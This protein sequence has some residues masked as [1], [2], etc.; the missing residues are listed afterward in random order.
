MPPRRTA[1]TVKVP[2][3]VNV[4]SEAVVPSWI[5]SSGKMSAS[6]N[7]SRSSRVT[8]TPSTVNVPMT[9]RS[10][11]PP[12]WIVVMPPWYAG[13]VTSSLGSAGSPTSSTTS[14]APTRVDSIVSVSLPWPRNSC[15]TSIVEVLLSVTNSP[16]SSTRMRPKLMPPGKI[17]GSPNA[18]S[19][20]KSRSPAIPKPVRPVDVS[21]PTPFSTELSLKMLR[22][23]ICSASSGCV[24]IPMRSVF[25]SPGSST[26]VASERSAPVTPPSTASGPARSPSRWSRTPKILTSSR[27]GGRS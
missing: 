24:A 5:V 11:L 15:R 16:S 1:R 2:S 23:S 14:A 4:P 12:P 18:V 26:A 25:A 6:A 7:C 20:S 22:T 9:W 13:A 17:A 27:P 8:S 19:P 3:E 21:V 10:W